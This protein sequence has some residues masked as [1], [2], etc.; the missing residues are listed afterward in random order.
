MK[1]MMMA[2]VLLLS[3]VALQATFAS[4]QDVQRAQTWQRAGG[5][6]VQDAIQS[7]RLTGRPL[8]RTPVLERGYAQT[9]GFV[10]N[11]PLAHQGFQKVQK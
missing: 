8:V 2:L 11:T 5:Q 9:R 1:T 7:G 3:G 6:R 4:P 10:S